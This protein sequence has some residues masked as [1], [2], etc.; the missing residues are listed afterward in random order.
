[1]RAT[2]LT[3]KLRIKGSE[4]NHH[5]R[6][7]QRRNMNRVRMRYVLKWYNRGATKLRYNARTMNPTLYTSIANTASGNKSWRSAASHGTSGYA[8]MVSGASPG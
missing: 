4:P 1:M 2:L 5:V 8:I 6:G 7:F 3:S